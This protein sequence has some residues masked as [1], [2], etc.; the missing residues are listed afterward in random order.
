MPLG[1]KEQ[2]LRLEI[3]MCN[4]L[5]VQVFHTS[6]N[7]LETTLDFARTHTTLLDCR[8]KVTTR[9]KLHDLTPMRI[10][11][12]DEI[13]CLNDVDMVQGGGDAEFSSE[14]LDVVFLGF[15]FSTF[16]EFLDSIQLLLAPVPF[17]REPHNAGGTF[18]DSNLLAHTVLLAQAS[19]A[20]ASSRPCTL[21]SALP[22]VVAIPIDTLCIRLSTTTCRSL[23]PSATQLGV[24]SQEILQG[25]LVLLSIVAVHGSWFGSN[26]SLRGVK[27]RRCA[28]RGRGVGS[29]SR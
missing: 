11:V 28:R 2:I 18:P 7:L 29:R 5:T 24:G 22:I 12:L 13:D 9:T 25:E 3:P 27:I 16:A 10:L 23:R 1:I 21:S 15:V 14:L 19:S 26:G 6:Q 17:V 20:I 4:T 8:I